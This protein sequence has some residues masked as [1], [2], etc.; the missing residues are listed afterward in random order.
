M[1][2]KPIV[3][4]AAG[5]VLIAAVVLFFSWRA[6]RKATPAAVEPVAATAPET[7]PIQNPVPVSNAAAAL[8]SLQASDAPLQDALSGVMGKSSVSSLLKPE[9]LVRH[10]VVTV[11]NLSR[12]RAAIELRPTRPLSGTFAVKG[13]EQSSSIDPVNYQRY[14]GYVQALQMMDAKQMTG[15]Y[16]HFYPLFQ[17]AYQDLGYPNG[18]FNDRL[19]ETVDNLL[20]TPDTQDPIALVRPNVMYQFADPNLEQLSAGQK[21]LL[22]MGPANEQIVKAKLRELRA[23]LA[24]RARSSDRSRSGSGPGG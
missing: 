9:M 1:L 10:F 13:D 22:R 4:V 12:K 15:V 6:M 19:V 23:E 16:F 20:A 14:N 5:V 3:L 17:Q 18:Y 11:D 8:P 2:R 7:P 21:L 24:T